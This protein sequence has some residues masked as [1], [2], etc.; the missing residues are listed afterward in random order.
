MKIVRKYWQTDSKTQRLC[1]LAKRNR[2]NVSMSPSVCRFRLLCQSRGQQQQ[3]VNELRMCRTEIKRWTET[4]CIILPTRVTVPLTSPTDNEPTTGGRSL[5]PLVLS[6]FV[7]KGRVVL[8][9]MSL[10][11]W[12]KHE[13]NSEMI[14]IVVLWFILLW[15]LIIFVVILHV[16]KFL[17]HVTWLCNSKL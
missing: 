9:F 15:F 12:R 6:P 4:E 2:W 14:Y 1:N 11:L 13:G 3:P 8:W 16:F 10:L 17:V 5:D 7:F